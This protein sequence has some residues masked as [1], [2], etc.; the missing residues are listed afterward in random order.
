MS[1]K[2]AVRGKVGFFSSIRSRLA[3]NFRRF[4]FKRETWLLERKSNQR[5]DEPAKTQLLH[6]ML[7][8]VGGPQNYYSA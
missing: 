2:K 3:F 1:T 8:V 5:R 4:A 7:R 6:A